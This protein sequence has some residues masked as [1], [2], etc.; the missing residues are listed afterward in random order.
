MKYPLFTGTATA[1]VTPFLEDESID[2]K[3]FKKLIDS[4]IASGVEAIVVCGSTGE[5]ATL[6]AKE[7]I[8]IYIQAVEYSAG[9]VPIIAGTGSNNT[10]DSVALT[11]IAK[12]HGADAVLL[13]APYYNKPSQEGLF[14]HFKAIADA[15]DIPQIIYNVPG[16][17]SVN[18]SAKTQLKIARE[19]K[20]VVGTKEASGNLEQMMHII[21]NAPKHFTL[22]SGDD[23][24]TLPVIT[25]GGKG[26]ISVI[27]NYA[28]KQFGDCVRAAL[29]GK[30]TE[31][32]KIHYN[33]LELMSL[34]FIETNPSPVKAALSLMGYIKEYLRLPMLPVSEENKEKIKNALKMSGIQ[35]KKAG[36]K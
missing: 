9:R 34:N 20:N 32:Y 24:L 11:L 8:S 12:E 1:I 27:S 19:C 13:V 28:P 26:V 6:S 2:F 5:S 33:L 36:K 25:M 30:F 3:S 29:K 10:Q 31:A 21:K 15:V 16:R 14:R 23:V 17:T 4:Q 22:Y 7:K 18:I 35:L